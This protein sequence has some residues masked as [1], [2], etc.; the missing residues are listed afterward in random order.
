MDAPFWEE[1]IRFLLAV[2]TTA[3]AIALVID[4]R[5]S[6]DLSISPLMA[7]LA[8]TVGAYAAWRWFIVVLGL[9]T[10][11]GDAWARDVEPY[12]RSIGNVL[13]LLVFLAALLMSIFHAK[14]R[15]GE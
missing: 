10:D 7:Y 6:R 9:T 8:A 13:L 12:V 4:W 2:L 5:R 15:G 1:L 3:T 14:G 11:A